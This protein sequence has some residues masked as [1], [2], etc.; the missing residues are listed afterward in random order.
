LVRGQDDRCAQTAP[1][2][3]HVRGHHGPDD[4]CGP[5]HHDEQDDHCGPGHHDEQDGHHGPDDLFCR[6]PR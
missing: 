6:C 5:G 1:G 4:H 2:G 3:H